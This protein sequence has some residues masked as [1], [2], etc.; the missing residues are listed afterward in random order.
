M[1]VLQHTFTDKIFHISLLI[2]VEL[3]KQI[4]IFNNETIKNTKLLLVFLEL[5]E[6]ENG[7][8]WL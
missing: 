5:V 2:H 4:N 3:H 7:S 8:I 1:M 6:S